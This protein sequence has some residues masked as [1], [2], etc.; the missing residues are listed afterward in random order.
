MGINA[1]LVNFVQCKTTQTRSWFGRDLQKEYLFRLSRGCVHGCQNNLC[2]V[3]FCDHKEAKHYYV[4]STNPPT[5]WLVLYEYSDVLW[6]NEA[7]IDFAPALKIDLSINDPSPV[8]QTHIPIPNA[9]YDKVKDHIQD[10]LSFSPNLHLQIL[11]YCMRAEEERQPA[12][13]LLLK[14]GKSEVSS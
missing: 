12:F 9:L 5:Y 1:L 14:E 11:L 3:D 4:A 8:R 10:L 2:D 13:L 6:H 7:E